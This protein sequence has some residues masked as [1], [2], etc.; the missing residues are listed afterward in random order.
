MEEEET[1]TLQDRLQC[2]S[3]QDFLSEKGKSRMIAAFFVP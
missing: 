1:E 3:A 2:A